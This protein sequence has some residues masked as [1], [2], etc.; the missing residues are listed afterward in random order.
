[1]AAV[2]VKWL[3]CFACICCKIICRDVRLYKYLFNSKKPRTCLQSLVSWDLFS[4]L[5]GLSNCLF[6]W[7]FPKFF[8]KNCKF[9]E[10]NSVTTGSKCLSV[11]N[12]VRMLF[13]ELV[14]IS[15]FVIASSEIREG[16]FT[17]KR[18]IQTLQISHTRHRIAV[19]QSELNNI[20]TFSTCSNVLH[21]HLFV[22]VSFFTFFC[23]HVL[24]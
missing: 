10:I 21:I 18:I 8:I 12:C 15:R 3:S 9:S 7:F 20:S 1:M 6:L 22:L 5:I 11:Q 14:N 2:D 24:D 23:P 4:F 17:C 16:N 19:T 13:E